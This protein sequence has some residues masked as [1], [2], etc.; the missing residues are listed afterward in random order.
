VCL[1]RWKYTSPALCRHDERAGRA[2]LQGKI[3]LQAYPTWRWAPRLGVHGS[4]GARAASSQF[5]VGQAP[6]TH[7]HRLESDPGIELAARARGGVDTSHAPISTGA[8]RATRIVP[9]S[10]S[11]IPSCAGRRR[12][13]SSISRIMDSSTRHPAARRDR[14]AHPSISFRH[15]VSSDPPVVARERR[16]SVA[17]HIWVRWM[18]R[19]PWSTTGSGAPARSRWA[20][21]DRLERLSR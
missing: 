14:D 8:S 11:R 16:P 3:H 9:V 19:P 2:H 17:G 4:D 6:E 21:A 13:S 5:R 15:A 7:R 20:E 18:T 1:P 10:T 12:R